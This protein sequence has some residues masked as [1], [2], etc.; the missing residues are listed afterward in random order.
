MIH[1][2]LLILQ[3]LITAFF[4]TACS[5]QTEL[6]ST[7]FALKIDDAALADEANTDE[8]LAYGRTYSEQRFS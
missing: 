5:E 6:V 7:E 3:I 4:L 8:W 1:N 2:V